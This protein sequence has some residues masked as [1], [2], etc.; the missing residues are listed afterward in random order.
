MPHSPER[1]FAWHEREGAFE[2]LSPPWMDVRC[3]RRS[4]GITDGS[5]VTLLVRKGPLSL[6]WELAHR[7]Y[8]KNE[9]FVDYQVK[10]PFDFWQ[11]AH[12]VQA[13][14]GGALLIDRAE[15]RLPLP[16]LGQIFGGWAVNADLERLFRYRHRLTR[17][18]LDTQAKYGSGP[19]KI[20][21]TGGTG[22]IGSQLIPFLL[23]Q[24]HSVVQLVRGDHDKQEAAQAC[25]QK[26]VWD[27]SAR[28]I[29][30]PLPDDLDAL[31]HLGGHNVAAGLWTDEVK[32]AIAR[33]RVESTNYL[34][35]IFGRMKKPPPVFVCA[36]AM[37]F[38]G[39]T[40]E[41]AVDEEA[42]G[43]KGFLADVCR[44]WEEAAAGAKAACPDMRIVNLR[45]SG[46]L[47]PRGG[48]LG[49]LLPLFMAGCGGPVGDGGQY[50]SWISL[51]DML[52]C[53]LH[54]IVTPSISGPL[55]A[56]APNCPT[57][58]EFAVTLGKVLGRPAFLPLPGPIVKVF[59]GEMG[60]ALLLASRRLV[61]QKLQHS[62]YEFL[63]PELG[64]A[65]K[66]MLGR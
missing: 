57:Y 3:L 55:N 31:V 35:Q 9:R 61:P 46:V 17:R 56:V 18:D 22:L 1:V 23:T 29:E 28:S 64:E 15:Y 12:L 52:G 51:D 11:Q 40:G 41:R 8:I 32:Q 66:Y 42:P 47:T 45:V 34:V 24:G 65:L 16:P 14:E 60:E 54:A 7:D 49:K 36:S 5:Q 2:R 38:Y 62:G 21:V 10:G 48:P 19:L 63:D 33:S 37:D 13:E 27:P 44:S 6:K 39:D 20:A 4:G 43:G 26:I 58:G 59:L 50:F 53:I 25:W 30:K